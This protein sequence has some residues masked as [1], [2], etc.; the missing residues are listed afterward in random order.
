MCGY[1]QYQLLYESSQKYSSFNFDAKIFFVRFSSWIIFFDI[2]N[3]LFLWFDCIT[4][5]SIK[6]FLA[7]IVALIF[8]RM[9]LQIFLKTKEKKEKESF[10]RKCRFFIFFPSKTAWCVVWDFT[11]D[12]QKLKFLLFF[13]LLSP[14]IKYLTEK[15]FRGYNFA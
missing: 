5:N 9:F 15:K 11:E 3:I 7:S 6:F 10:L 12:F 14:S 1:W 4:Y 8:Y 13:D 2:C